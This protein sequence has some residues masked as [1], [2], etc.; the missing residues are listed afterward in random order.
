MQRSL[1]ISC[2]IHLSVVGVYLGSRSYLETDEVVDLGR[3]IRVVTVPAPTPIVFTAPPATPTIPNVPKPT[4]G[5]VTPVPNVP[6]DP[7]IKTGTGT[8]AIPGVSPTP[9]G[10]EGRKETL[11]VVDG[12]Y[13]TPET[14]VY[15]EEEPA[16]VV[17][18][19]PKYPDFA[20]EAGIEGRVLLQVLVGR[21]GRVKAVRVTRGVRA[22]DE[23]A[24]E[25]AWKWVFR[26]ALAANRQPVA[27]WVEVPVDFRLQP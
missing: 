26:P 3:M 2:A 8:S 12:E 14:F 24:A 18:A 22:L 6:V 10:R 19:E 4:V 15:R 7:T 5:R 16:L 23:A 21:D 27:V 25:A 1:V 11:V 9:S 13:P 20:R 17:H